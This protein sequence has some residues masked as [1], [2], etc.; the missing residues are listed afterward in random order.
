MPPNSSTQPPPKDSEPFRTVPKI[1]EAFR[2]VP[3][4]AESFRNLRNASE[5]NASHTLTVREATRMFEAAGTPR[6][7]RSI[8]NWCQ[9]NKMGV[10]RLDAFFDLN[11]RR[12]FITPQSVELAIQEELAKASKT[13]E[14]SP[15]GPVPN[16]SERK[17]TREDDPES[18]P[19]EVKSF[20]QEIMDLK[21]T[22][23]AKDMFIEQ[24]QKEREGFTAERAG[25]VEKLMGFNRKVGEL[26]A[27]LQQ[28]GSGR[29]A[30]PGDAGQAPASSA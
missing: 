8:V 24:L 23:R 21:I 15:P 10:A 27:A 25:Y 12:Y 6:T 19:E 17:A 3:N 22:N 16:A 29:P 13:A 5:R 30:Q 18:A 11:E 20:R 26:E 28:L 9:L 1:A 2:T 14:Q 4:D 7:E